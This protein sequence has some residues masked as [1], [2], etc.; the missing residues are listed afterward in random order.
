MAV[1]IESNSRPLFDVPATRR[2]DG[3]AATA[4]AEGIVLIDATTGA[5]VSTP[6]SFSISGTFTPSGSY[7]QNDAVGSLIEL[8]ISAATGVSMANKWISVT[9]VHSM[10]RADAAPTN[11]ALIPVLFNDNPTASTWTNDSPTVLA[12]ADLTKVIPWLSVSTAA[13]AAVLS[14]ALCCNTQWT[15]NGG[16][17]VRCNSAGKLWLGFTAT[18][19][20]TVLGTNPGV[21]W[22]VQF[23]ADL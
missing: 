11:V 7:I 12:A 20:I 1:G 13:G 3:A 15:M 10:Q 21:L 16:L 14:N 22:R 19:T 2:S 5:A 8:D 6:Q 9:L 23:S 17:R 18:G 4:K